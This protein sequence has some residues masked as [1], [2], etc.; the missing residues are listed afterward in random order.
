MKRT[1]KTIAEPV[2]YAYCEPTWATPLSKEHIRKV[3]PEGLML[4]GGVPGEALCGRDLARGWD[5]PRNVDHTSA[6]VLS[7][8][9][10]GD[11]RVFLCPV[12][13][14]TYLKETADG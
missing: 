2:T 5:V 14:D 4:G 3:G 8:P 7:S 6:L 13:A 1:R 12:C 11:G 9:R 10:L